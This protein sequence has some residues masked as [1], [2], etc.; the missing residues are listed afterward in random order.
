MDEYGQKNYFEVKNYKSRQSSGAALE[1]TF[2]EN[3]VNFARKIVK[4]ILFTNVRHL[5][6]HS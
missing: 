1:K 5:K 3:C 4:K 6:P 2:K